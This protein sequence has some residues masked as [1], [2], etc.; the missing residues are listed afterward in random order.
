MLGRNKSREYIVQKLREQVAE[1]QKDMDR[2]N[3]K[4]MERNSGKGN[5]EDIEAMAQLKKDFDR[6]FSSLNQSDYI[7]KKSALSDHYAQGQINKFNLKIFEM[8][9]QN[10]KRQLAKQT[11]N[12][13]VSKEMMQQV[14]DSQKNLLEELNS[15]QKNIP[16]Q[17][18]KIPDNAGNMGSR[19]QWW[20][21]YESYLA[22]SANVVKHAEQSLPGI[23]TSSI[24]ENLYFIL[25]DANEMINPDIIRVDPFSK[26]EIQ[27]RISQ[28]S[29]VLVASHSVLSE[30][31][32]PTALLFQLELLGIE[33]N[34]PGKFMNGVEELDNLIGDPNNLKIFG[35]EQYQKP[36][37]ELNSKII[38]NIAG[39]LSDQ[40]YNA[41]AKL[42]LNDQTSIDN[43]NA[44]RFKL[45]G[46]V[47]GGLR[48]DSLEK[49]KW[50][51]ERWIRIA[52]HLHKNGDYFNADIIT[53][54]L[55][56]FNY[57]NDGLSEDASLRLKELESIYNTFTGQSQLQARKDDRDISEL[58]PFKFIKY[59]AKNNEPSKLTGIKT[60]K[61]AENI[62]NG[63]NSLEYDAVLGQQSRL[64]NKYDKLRAENTFLIRDINN[65]AARTN[66]SADDIKRVNRIN[67]VL[68]SGNTL[69]KKL[70]SEQIADINK[71]ISK[72]KNESLKRSIH[73]LSVIISSNIAMLE[74]NK[75]AREDNNQ[76]VEQY[77]VAKQ[78][79]INEFKENL[80]SGK[81]EA[82]IFDTINSLASSFPETIPVS[83][84]DNKNS[85]SEKVSK[86]VDNKLN[87][88]SAHGTKDIMRSL[89]TNKPNLPNV[90]KSKQSSREK[91][92]EEL[93]QYAIDNIVFTP[94][95]QDRDIETRKKSRDDFGKNVIKEFTDKKTGLIDAKRLTR[96][97]NT[98][99]VNLSSREEIHYNI[100]K[101]NMMSSAEKINNEAVNK[102]QNRQELQEPVNMV[103][104]SLKPVE[105]SK[106]QLDSELHSLKNLV[107]AKI[108]EVTNKMSDFAMQGRQGAPKRVLQDLGKISNDIDDMLKKYNKPNTSDSLN[109]YR[110]EFDNLLQICNRYKIRSSMQ[111]REVEPEDGESKKI[112]LVKLFT[113][114]CRF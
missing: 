81:Q 54:K 26:E 2:V 35:G 69:T 53:E 110:N 8:E 87:I 23:D 11:D 93:R 79:D 56:E 80:K 7:T 16:V 86:S 97:L 43:I 65:L 30:Y 66:F 57:L 31:K 41:F 100:F 48:S 78:N 89:D 38:T 9:S 104:Q 61:I 95:Y 14:T 63:K 90:K 50:S 101:Q 55:R 44:L 22:R 58:I 37:R 74:E 114:G 33:M 32:P 29:Q 34:E 105:L 1:L 39:A 68:K 67:A 24:R 109:S 77:K 75:K 64:K 113:G 60:N 102:V 84:K 71:N 27:E 98:L 108:K 111:P 96:F 28:S 59:D 112:Q 4:L 18:E 17:V 82:I 70:T 3:I 25:Q 76:E 49:Q 51:Y 106:E 62:F 15:L 19:G 91:R 73:Q 21:A 47:E 107:D 52:D 92:M 85:T 40:A 10:E 83:R 88:T 46:F 99:N 42:K 6:E 103:Q 20:L 5:K 36:I 45:L 72:M 13:V 12:L 94:P